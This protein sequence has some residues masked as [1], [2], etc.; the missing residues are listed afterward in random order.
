M[1]MKNK[2]GQVVGNLVKDWQSRK[3]PILREI[4]GTF[5]T[6][7]PLDINQH[8]EHLFNAFKHEDDLYTYLPFGPFETF[9]S[10]RLWLQSARLSKLYFTILDLKSNTF[11]GIAS[12]HDI[13]TDHGVI[14]V[15][16]IIYSK[17]LQKTAAGTEAMYLMMK[18][19]FEGLGYRRYQWRCNALNSASRRAAERLG[20][21]FEG[22][23]RQHYVV[24]GRNRDTAWYSIIDTEWPHL[25]YK[26]EQWLLPDNFDKGNQKVKLNNINS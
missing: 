10:F 15:G 9:D 8:A 23:F 12:F 1:L 13:D 22:I 26:F 11:Q 19:V 18:E 5:C 3:M 2:F 14:E 21:T 16:S 7:L 6:L 17:V 4:K 25:K 20:F 24:K